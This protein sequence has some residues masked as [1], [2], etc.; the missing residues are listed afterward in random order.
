MPPAAKWNNR[1][2]VVGNPAFEGAIK[3]QGLAGALKKG[4]QQL[5]P[6]PAI[7]I[8]ATSGRWASPKEL[9]TGHIEPCTRQRSL[10]NV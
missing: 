5:P 6:I 9:S 1:F 4:M 7:R 2:F 3:Y 8:P 10:P